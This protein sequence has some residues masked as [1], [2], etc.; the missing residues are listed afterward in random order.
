MGAHKQNET[1]GMGWDG[2]DLKLETG[3]YPGIGMHCAG[4]SGRVRSGPRFTECLWSLAILV[5]GE[6]HVRLFLR[7]D[8]Q[9]QIINSLMGNRERKH[10]IAQTN[11]ILSQ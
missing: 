2:M 4:C 9:K 5:G 7:I 8:A 11:H 3:V 1:N 6:Q 10:S